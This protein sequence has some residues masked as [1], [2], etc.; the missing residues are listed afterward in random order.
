MNLDTSLKTGIL[1]A[2]VADIEVLMSKREME[3]T[4]KRYASMAEGKLNGA[5]YESL[6][7]DLEEVSKTTNSVN[8]APKIRA[9]III[10]VGS[11]DEDIP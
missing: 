5:T 11:K 4:T 2:P 1:M 8:L 7:K 9:P 6:L 10:I 3:G